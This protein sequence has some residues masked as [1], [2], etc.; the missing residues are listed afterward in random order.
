LKVYPD[1]PHAHLHRALAA[2][3]EGLL[4]EALIAIND[5]LQL[6]GHWARSI[7]LKV[8]VLQALERD[9][10]AVRT[11]RRALML[12]TENPYGLRQLLV[13][14]LSG[15]DRAEEALEALLPLVRQ[16]PDNPSLQAKRGVLAMAVEDWEQAR[17]AFLKLRHNPRSLVASR[18]T[19]FN[20][21]V[22]SYFLGVLAE[23]DGDIQGAIDYYY[24]VEEGDYVGEDRYFHKS[25]ARIGELLWTEG[26]VE[27]A[28]MHLQVSRAL[29]VE[30]ESVV[31]LY[32]AEADMLYGNSEHAAGYALLSEALE[33][34]PQND[35]LLYSRALHAERLGRLSQLEADLRKVLAKDPDHARALN[36]LGYTWVDHGIN[37]EEGMAYIQRAHEQLPEDAAILDSMGWAY[38]RLGDLVRAESFLRRAQTMMPEAEITAHLVEVLWKLGRH[39]EARRLYQSAVEQDPDNEFLE[40][41]ARRFPL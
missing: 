4:E 14:L 28:R 20:H 27:H 5:T 21:S 29:S 19:S 7:A 40:R 37:L 16:D 38:Y 1:D 13:N 33:R 18:P 22:S 34:Y 35:M 41:V 24:Q 25:R 6:R 9:D 2:K 10:E 17:R 12:Q 39:E 8:E 36:A 23:H 3:E 15:N 11:L 26:Q 30:D 32:V 31:Y